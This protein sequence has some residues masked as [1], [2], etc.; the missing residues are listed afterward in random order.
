MLLAIFEIVSYIRRRNGKYFDMQRFIE[1]KRG[2]RL[3]PEALEMEESVL[4]SKSDDYF[5]KILGVCKHFP[6]K[7][8]NPVIAVNQ[9]SIG[10]KQNSLF[11]LLG[12]NGAGKTT[13]MNLI[14]GEMP[15]DTG[16]IYVNGND[17]RNEIKKST[18]GYCPQFSDHLSDELTIYQTL[19]FFGIFFGKE[20]EERDDKIE[21]LMNSLNLDIH[22]DA[23]VKDL[24]PPLKQKLC[25]AIPFLSN[26]NLIILD[27]PTSVLD[28]ISRRKVHHLI[29]MNKG[30]KT[31]ILCT[32]MLD[33]AENL[34]DEI[35]IMID[36][37]IY[38]IG[39]PSFFANKYGKDFKID[40]LINPSNDKNS[41]VDQLISD[42][43]PLA[44]VMIN[45]GCS[46]VYNIPSNSITISK[47]FR[48]LQDIKD[49]NIGLEC[50]TCSVSNLEKTFL[51]LGEQAKKDISD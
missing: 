1:A 13:L 9:V 35:T 25:V 20:K 6:S 19:N 32:H 33:E 42:R 14:L 45:H 39:T 11:G 23:V 29:N 22:R 4:N 41:E 31:F 38:S 51:E 47:L 21:A 49:M 18:I 16:S 26:A 43:L 10:I 36:G 8:D 37:C 30:E 27:E 40:I 48:T 24:P 15:V 2:R 3:M 17:I 50:F 28:P 46:R 34:C 7:I 44:K 12:A 5:I